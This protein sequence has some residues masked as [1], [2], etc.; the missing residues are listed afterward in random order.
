MMSLVSFA[1]GLLFGLGLLVSGMADPAKVLSFLDMAGRWDPSL[2]LVM[3]AAVAVALPAFRAARRLAR[4]WVATTMRL[5]AA[6]RVDARLLGGSVLF[7]AGWG[8]A[9]FCPG[10]ALVAL[11][12]EPWR[13]APFALG[14]LGGMGTFEAVE[15]WRA[16]RRI[17]GD[18]RV[19]GTRAD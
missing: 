14:M 17:A 12:L 4:P 7:G 1:C 11:A 9:G 13:A 18:P 6:A 3:A 8:L 5:P 10:P 15:R 16:R 2:V 19:A